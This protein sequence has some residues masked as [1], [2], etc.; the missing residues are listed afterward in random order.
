MRR[1]ILKTFGF[2]IQA[3]AIGPAPIDVEDVEAVVANCTG[4]ILTNWETVCSEIS[5]FPRNFG[6]AGR[7]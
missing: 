7:S 6:L 1:S 5:H 3:S 2:R 4:S